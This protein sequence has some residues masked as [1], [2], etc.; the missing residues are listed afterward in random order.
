MQSAMTDGLAHTLGAKAGP[1]CVF[2]LAGLEPRARDPRSK[3][4]RCRRASP[5]E[6]NVTVLYPNVNLPLT[7]AMLCICGGPPSPSFHLRSSLI[8]LITTVTTA[9]TA[10]TAASD[11]L[12]PAQPPVHGLSPRP[13]FNLD[14]HNRREALALALTLAASEYSLDHLRLSC[15]TAD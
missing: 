12:P 15:R 11:C 7:S 8:F 6:R 14:V 2:Y 9:T 10:T 13:Q 4:L 1:C 5:A 3:M